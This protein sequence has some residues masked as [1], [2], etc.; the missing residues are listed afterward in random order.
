MG[1]LALKGWNA[2]QP[3]CA[4]LRMSY[5]GVTNEIA[6][7]IRAQHPNA[8]QPSGPPPGAAPSSPSIV[9]QGGGRSVD[10]APVPKAEGG[11]PNVTG[12]AGAAARTLPGAPAATQGASPGTAP[13]KTLLGG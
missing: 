10:P 6:A 1:C 3:P 2:P 11:A 5:I 13:T 9:E 12:G 4:S 8:S 7:R